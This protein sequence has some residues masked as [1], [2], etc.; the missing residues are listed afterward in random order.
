M[1]NLNNLTSKIMKDAEDKK[2]VILADAENEKNKIKK[3]YYIK[4]KK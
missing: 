1:S 3:Y 4:D 2:A